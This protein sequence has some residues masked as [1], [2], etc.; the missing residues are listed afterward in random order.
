MSI[1]P[2]DVGQQIST[3]EMVSFKEVSVA[4]KV[5]TKQSFEKAKQGLEEAKKGA[6]FPKTK[7][8]EV[9]ESFNDIMKI[10]NV[11]L[12]F[13]VHEETKRIMVTIK[14]VET[15]KIIRQIPPKE[16]LDM[17]ARILEMV[18]ILIDEKA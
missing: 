17:V 10:F 5:E 3:K 11:Q 12:K 16:I 8:D 9:L 2:V 6:G 4:S 15:D 7:I 14:D 1:K 18:G 13:S